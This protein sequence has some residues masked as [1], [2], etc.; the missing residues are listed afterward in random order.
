MGWFGKKVRVVTKTET[1][2]QV[3]SL[4]ERPEVQEQLRKAGLDPSAL[5]LQL[6]D[7]TAHME[8]GNVKFRFKATV[9]EDAGAQELPADAR[10]VTDEAEFLRMLEMPGFLD[11]MKAKGMDRA[12]VEAQFRAGK[13]QMFE[14]HTVDRHA[15]LHLGDSP[16]PPAP[17]RSLSSDDGDEV[18]KKG[19]L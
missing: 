3:A 1:P 7:G 15:E 2:E 18:W 11:A 8:G 17:P 14:S 10:P 13:I 5:E 9:H 12:E 4:L 6:R 19:R 16:Q